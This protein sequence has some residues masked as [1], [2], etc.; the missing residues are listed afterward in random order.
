MGTHY[1]GTDEEI[2]ALDSYIKLSRAYDTVTTRINSH[3]LAYD[4]TISQFGVLEAL[5]HL[6]PLQPTQLAQKI[7]KTGGNLTLV[8][9]NLVKRELVTRQRRENDRRC[10]DI[11]LT[12]QGQTLIESILPDH[13]VGV[14]QTM[15]VLTPTE[16]EQLAHLCR[17]LGLGNSN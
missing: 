17:K 13:V 3:L 2:L 4:L 12:A 7:L 15:N 9:T 11:Q 6:G 1:T 16:Q 14:V 5:Y 8:I 10:I